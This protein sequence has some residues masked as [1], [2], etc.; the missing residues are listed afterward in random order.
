MESELA[1]GFFDPA[2]KR[3]QP[4][5]GLSFAQDAS[6]EG[7]TR[8]SPAGR[9]IADRAAGRLPSDRRRRRVRAEVA[10]LHDAI[11][12]E[13]EQFAARSFHRGAIVTDPRHGATATQG[14]AQPGHDG[15][16]VMV[17]HI[18]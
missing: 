16:F 3:I 12:F 1:P 18:K 14:G 4:A 15:I 7:F 2:V 13:Q 9:D 5:A 8:F 10:L 6:D 17:V 11:G